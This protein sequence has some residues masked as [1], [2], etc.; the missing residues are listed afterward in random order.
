MKIQRQLSKKRGDKEY[1]RY[2][3]VLPDDILKKAGL[4]KGDELEAEAKKGEVRLRKK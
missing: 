1:Y 3:I 2:V 4:K